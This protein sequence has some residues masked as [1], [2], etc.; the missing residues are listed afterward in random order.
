MTKIGLE[1]PRSKL[2]NASELKKHDR[3]KYKQ[4]Q[5][6]A[7]ADIASE[8]EEEAGARRFRT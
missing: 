3:D 1:T 7:V 2:A 8:A 4:E 5:E 6:R